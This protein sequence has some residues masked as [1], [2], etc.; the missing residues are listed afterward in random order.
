MPQK[1]SHRDVDERRA[2]FRIAPPPHTIREFAIWFRPELTEPTLPINYL[3][4]PD[5]CSINAGGALLL[6]NI[7]ATGL[8]FSLPSTLLKPEDTLKPYVYAFL[9]LRKAMSGKLGCYVIFIGARP[10]HTKVTHDR[11]V[12]RNK[13][14]MRGVASNLS[15]SFQMFNVERAGI[16]ELSVWCEELARMGRGILPPLSPGLDMEY[17]LLEL[18]ASSSSPLQTDASNPA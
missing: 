9:K 10:V 13:I 1:S 3:G 16:R 18:A 14:T 8:C 15:K 17:L 12:I 6:E 11:S 7:S 5:F 4:R 2:C